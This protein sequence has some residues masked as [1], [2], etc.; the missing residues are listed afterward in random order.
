MPHTRKFSYQAVGEWP[1]LE[2]LSTMSVKHG[3]HPH[4]LFMNRSEAWL[5][6]DLL[7]SS[8]TVS[9]HD[10]YHLPSMNSGES[11]MLITEFPEVNGRD[12]SPKP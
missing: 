3:D 12:H 6:R 11:P 5:C 4:H 8:T 2:N 9:D 10:I 1:K 7:S